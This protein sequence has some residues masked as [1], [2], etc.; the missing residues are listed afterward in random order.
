MIKFAKKKR[1]KSKKTAKNTNTKNIIKLNTPFKNKNLIHTNKL[2]FIFIFILIIFVLLIIKIGYLQFVQGNE[3]KELAYKQQTINRIIS[4]KRGNIYDTTG[5]SLAIS[6][7][8]DTV[9]INPKKIE[10]SKEAETIALK[11]KV[12]K[13]LSD[14]FA[15]DYNEVYKKVNSQKNHFLQM[16]N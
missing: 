12:A 7:Q 10:G 11:E 16:I 15:L 3:L 1:G 9:T 13:G 2:K 4:P 5:K 8:V 14:I 6:A